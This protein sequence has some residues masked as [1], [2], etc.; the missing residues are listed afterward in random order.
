MSKKFSVLRLLSNLANSAPPSPILSAEEV[1][2]DKINTTLR[3]EP[4]VR[5]FVEEQADHYGV[6]TQQFIAMMLKGLMSGGSHEV[7]H[8]TSLMESRIY[9]IFARNK[10]SP[11]KVA[12]ILSSFGVTAP[13]LKDPQKLLSLMTP[14]VIFFLSEKFGVAE[15]WLSGMSD[16]VFEVVNFDGQPLQL[17]MHILEKADD[18]RNVSVHFVIEDGYKPLESGGECGWADC[19]SH[20]GFVVEL[21]N[22]TEGVTRYII[23][24]QQPWGYV[25]T[26]VE[27]KKIL[28]FLEHGRDFNFPVAGY[29]GWLV[30]SQ[31]FD[32]LFSGK[33]WPNEVLQC[34][35]DW[36]KT[37]I[38]T[39]MHLE[40]MVD[41]DGRA[42]EEFEA[43]SVA[44][45][46][47]KTKLPL[48]HDFYHKNFSCDSD[49]IRQ[50]LFS[51]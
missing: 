27:M 39:G 51:S 30:K 37:G 24:R 40:D 48:I 22:A 5:Q 21:V 32:R 49:M 7:V 26:R 18:I 2:G 19:E 42:L 34:P 35:S 28:Y 29:K 14:E 6:S 33:T 10:L 1:D 38:Y 8:Q 31:E 50:Y 47:S 9:D 41:Q 46:Y 43:K 11:V 16:N 25:R 3:L 45:E 15:N 12:A 13:M 4:V 20:A 17:I 36:A 23:A 44:Y